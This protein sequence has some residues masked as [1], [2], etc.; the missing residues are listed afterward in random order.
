MRE[1]YKAI[2]I[3]TKQGKKIIKRTLLFFPQGYIESVVVCAKDN[4]LSLDT[5]DGEV[6]VRASEIASIQEFPK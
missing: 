2:E 1:G 6:S 4:F 5:P 3:M